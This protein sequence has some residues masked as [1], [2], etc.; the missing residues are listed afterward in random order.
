MPYPRGEDLDPDARRLPDRI[1]DDRPFRRVAVVLHSEL[2]ETVIHVGNEIQEASLSDAFLEISSE[3]RR[4]RELPV[5]RGSGSAP[6]RYDRAR[7]AVEAHLRPSVDDG[8]FSFA[9]NPPLVRHQHLL[10][11]PD[12]LQGGED[13][14]GAGSDDDGVVHVA[15][16]PYVGFRPESASSS[17]RRTSVRNASMRSG[18]RMN[19]G[20][21]R[22]SSI[23]RGVATSDRTTSRKCE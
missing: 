8:A 7:G 4:Q 1:L 6:P 18:L 14:G 21:E 20:S 22:S 2:D 15:H 23:T 5:R 17:M 16:V 3:A 12:Q 19:A 9:D 10:A 11:R 13:T